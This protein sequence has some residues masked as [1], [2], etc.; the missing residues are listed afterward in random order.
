MS[1]GV[2]FENVCLASA[3]GYT[4]RFIHLEQKGWLR[5]DSSIMHATWVHALNN[6]YGNF[7]LASA[8]RG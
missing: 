5:D 2:A 7:G 3:A 6:A 4:G 8:P 1:N